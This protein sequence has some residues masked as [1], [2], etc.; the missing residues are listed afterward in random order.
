M[1]IL[2][3]ILVLQGFNTFGFKA[4]IGIIFVILS[5]PVAAHAIARAA[6]RA[7]IPLTKESIIDL[8]EADKE[9]KGK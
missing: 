1:G 4:I 6:H 9:L 5:S 3:G 2:A 8:Y 7:R